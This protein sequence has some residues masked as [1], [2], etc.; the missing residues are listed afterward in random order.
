ML[1]IAMAPSTS[2]F[3]A[4]FGEW[5]SVTFAGQGVIKKIPIFSALRPVSSI[6]SLRAIFA[7]TSIGA[8]SGITLSHSSGKRILISRT[9]AGHAELMIGFLSR[10]SLISL[11]VASLTSSAA[12]DTSK[13]PSKP[14]FFSPVST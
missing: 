5:I 14:I 7:A 11:R 13:T 10:F 6:A 4:K 8:S 3:S 2:D 12:R 9:T 1:E